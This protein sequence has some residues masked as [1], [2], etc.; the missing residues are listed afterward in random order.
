M[1]MI[2]NGDKLAVSLSYIFLGCQL[3][4]FFGCYFSF[5]FLYCCD[6]SCV[7]CLFFGFRHDI[8]VGFLFLCHSL[9]YRFRMFSLSNFEFSFMPLLFVFE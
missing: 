8:I 1:T 2:I 6:F 4:C 7:L 3:V 9:L 5:L